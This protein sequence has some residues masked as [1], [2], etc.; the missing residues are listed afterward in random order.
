MKPK[1]LKS[2]DTK[3]SKEI[4][5]ANIGESTTEVRGHVSLLLY[6]TQRKPG[7]LAVS[8]NLHIKLKILGIRR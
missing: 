4:A 8:G 5:V 1:S 2:Q 6:Q 3:Q 7:G